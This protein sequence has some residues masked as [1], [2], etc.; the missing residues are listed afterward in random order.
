MAITNY[1]TL[2]TAIGTWLAR[3]DLS[4]LIPDFIT[5]AE[6]DINS[7]LRCRYNEASASDTIASGVVAVPTGYLELVAAYIDK[8]VPVYLEPKALSWI[9][10]KYPSSNPSEPRFIGRRVADFVFG[11]YP[12]S[13]YTIQMYYHKKLDLATDT[14]N[15][16]LS[17]YP[18]M[19]LYGALFQAAAYT[20]D[21]EKEKAWGAKFFS[22]MERANMEE[23]RSVVSGGP[24]ASGVG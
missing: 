12:D 7:T 5:L 4:A 15:D 23:G 10:E 21:T 19:Y 8:S 20:R 22:S 24:T 11:P 18:E 16:V 6:S 9:L 2:Q 17:N 14:T 3:A 1:T 13:N